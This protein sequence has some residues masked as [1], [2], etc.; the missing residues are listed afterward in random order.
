[1]MCNNH[2]TFIINFNVTNKRTGI[3]RRMIKNIGTV[4]INKRKIVIYTFVLIAL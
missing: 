1:M 2:R 4:K 3:G